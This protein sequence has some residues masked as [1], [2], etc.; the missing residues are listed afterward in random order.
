MNEFN[1][2]KDGHAIYVRL[3]ISICRSNSM[4][5]LS[6]NIYIENSEESMDTVK[7]VDSMMLN[8]SQYPLSKYIVGFELSGNPY[9]C[10]FSQEMN[11][12]IGK[13]I[14][15]IERCFWVW[16]KLF[17]N[18]QLDPFVCYPGI[19]LYPFILERFRIMNKS[20][21]QHFNTNHWELDIVYIMYLFSLKIDSY[22]PLPYMMLIRSIRFI[23]R[24]VQ[25][26]ISR[27]W[28]WNPYKIILYFLMC[29]S[30]PFHSLSIQM[31]VLSFKQLFQRKWHC[32]WSPLEYPNWI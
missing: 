11:R 9:V 5:M 19:L 23:L 3:I 12:I 26:P 4:Y 2:K 30:I 8:P 29:S 31:I 18:H 25:L 22:S 28:A 24:S 16:M 21:Y 10:W 17:K 20:F 27:L 6:T 32:L 7:L 15:W 13:N 14:W 1:S